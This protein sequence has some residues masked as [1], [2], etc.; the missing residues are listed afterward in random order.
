ME[1]LQRLFPILGEIWLANGR[2][3]AS[4]ESRLPLPI[5]C[6]ALRG[7][8]PLLLFNL[9]LQVGSDTVL[10]AYYGIRH[11][12]PEFEGLVGKLLVDGWDNLGYGVERGKVNDQVLLLLEC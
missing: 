9:G 7:L 5:G 4:E 1:S 3:G 12:I 2:D 11:A 8:L 10:L 6:L